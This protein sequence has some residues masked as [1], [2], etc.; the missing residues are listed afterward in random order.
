MVFGRL[1]VLYASETRRRYYVC[2]CSC[3]NTTEVRVDHLVRNETKKC[4][5]C[6]RT[7][8]VG[9]VI[10]GI[11]VLK[12]VKSDE[13]HSQYYELECTCGNKF[14]TIIAN[15]ISGHTSSC[16]HISNKYG[17]LSKDPR[18]RNWAAMIQRVTNPNH[19]SYAHYHELIK[20]KIV[21]EE[22][23]ESPK[24]FYDELGEKPSPEYTVDRIDNHLGYIKGNI[25]WASR[26]TQQ[27]NRETVVGISGRHYIYYNGGRHKWE[28]YAMVKGKKKYI[29]AYA[30][31][32][33]AISAQDNYIAKLKVGA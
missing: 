32:E 6:P 30:D 26:S 12:F 23:L 4:S 5:K 1:T 3:G 18:Y 29:G 22:W 21:E 19:Q 7:D 13:Y 10:N 16:G 25:R 31:L 9:R 2:K 33:D 17:N 14:V 28:V 24:G 8:Y 15:V 11:K 27:R 20:G